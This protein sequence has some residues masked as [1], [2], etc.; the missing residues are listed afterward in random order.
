MEKSKLYCDECGDFLGKRVAVPFKFKLVCPECYR[1]LNAEKTE[2]GEHEASVDVE[3]TRE[4]EPVEFETEQPSLALSPKEIVKYLDMYVIGQEEAKKTLAVAAYNHYK[5][6][7]NKSLGLKKSNVLMY[8]PTGSGKTYL[9]QKLAEIL[10][11]PMIIADASVFTE[12]GYRGAKADGV[13]ADLYYASGCDKERTEHGIVVYDEFDKLSNNYGHKGDSKTS[14]GG[15]VQFQILKLIEGKRCT[16][17]RENGQKVGGVKTNEPVQID[18]TNIL[19]ICAGAFVGLGEKKQH[20]TKQIGFTSE[21]TSGESNKDTEKTKIDTEDFLKFGIIPELLGRLPTVVG[22][23][24]LAENDICK[25]LE[26]SN[27]SVLDAYCSYFQAEGIELIF[28]TDA[29][30]EIAHQA[31]VR[32]VG[33][34]GVQT[35]VEKIMQPLV[36][37]IFSDSS[38]E[39]CII[40]REYVLGTD[41]PHI[42]R[43]E[44]EGTV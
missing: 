2:A 29:I 21:I 35:I 8:G 34:R 23:G 30:Q 37:D 33:A 12:A 40:T 14:T 20:Q 27:D 36:Y 41:E 42:L 31:Y 3:Q 15:M 9:I 32:G 18:T 26:E 13:I 28:Q 25:I 5:R 10:S 39:Q 22:L 6:M 16:I 4:E 19:F 1:E 38:V 17:S 11:V 43:R 7:N 24:M 44:E